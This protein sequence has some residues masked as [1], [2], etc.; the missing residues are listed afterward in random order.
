MR[1]G[2]HRHDGR[3]PA[4][5]QR[6]PNVHNP[7]DP[8][9][10]SAPPPGGIHIA[11]RTTVD[12]PRTASV[13]PRARFHCPVPRRFL[14]PGL[15]AGA[16]LSAQRTPLESPNGANRIIH[17]RGDFDRIDPDTGRKIIRPPKFRPCRGQD[18]HFPT[19]ARQVRRDR[20]PPEATGVAVAPEMVRDE[21][22]PRARL[23]TRNPLCSS[24]PVTTASGDSTNVSDR[25]LSIG[26]V[27]R[28]RG[29]ASRH[30]RCIVLPTGMPD[31]W[32]FMSIVH[33]RVTFFHTVARLGPDS[34]RIGPVWPGPI[35]DT[36]PATAPSRRAETGSVGYQVGLLAVVAPPQYQDCFGSRQ[37]FLAPRL[38]L[39]PESNP[40]AERPPGVLTARSLKHGPCWGGL[41]QEPCAAPPRP[42]NSSVGKPSTV[43]TKPWHLN[44]R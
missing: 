18:I 36:K 44:F 6:F 24:R 30:R 31:D 7:T 42:S 9:E 13:D 32:G 27:H 12:S 35:D 2:T 37:G 16:T 3:R 41:L 8:S 10:L 38:R 26:H 1:R 39:E 29:R 19:R 33:H 40:E 4:S 43:S 15:G 11:H 20:V 23:H 34:V 25:L 28:S 5:S 21:K 17:P 22:E 14:R